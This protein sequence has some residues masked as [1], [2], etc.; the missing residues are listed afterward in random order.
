MIWTLV[1]AVGPAAAVIA[2]VVASG[3]LALKAV[4]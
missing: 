1:V 3:S 4:S 2:K